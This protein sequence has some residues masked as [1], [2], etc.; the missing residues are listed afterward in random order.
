MKDIPNI[1]TKFDEIGHY[2]WLGSVIQMIHSSCTKPEKY[3]YK[4]SSWMEKNK[5]NC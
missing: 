3:Y 4:P 2:T 5:L 1:L